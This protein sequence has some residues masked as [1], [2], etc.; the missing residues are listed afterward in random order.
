[1]ILLLLQ[2]LIVSYGSLLDRRHCHCPKIEFLDASVYGETGGTQLCEG[3]IKKRGRLLL[4]ARKE[5]PLLG[6]AFLTSIKMCL[7]LG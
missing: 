7:R 2:Y 3:R 5:N 1:M 4:R 6:K